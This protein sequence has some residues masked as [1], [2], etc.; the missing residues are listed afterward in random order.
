MVV[1]FNLFVL[2]LH[3]DS[4]AG[5][6]GGIVNQGNTVE[7]NIDGTTTPSPVMATP[8]INN[9]AWNRQQAVC[10]RHAFKTYGSAKNPNHVL[11]NLNMTVAKGSM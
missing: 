7:G 2:S 3:S 9:V 5:G 8:G 11:Q 4:T 6:G 10:V 1:L